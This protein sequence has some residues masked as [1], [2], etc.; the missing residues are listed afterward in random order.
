VV[1][2]VDSRRD[3]EAMRLSR[4]I[5][6]LERVAGELQRIERLRTLDACLEAPGPEPGT[7]ETFVA[8]A[9]RVTVHTQAP[10]PALPTEIIEAD[11]LDEL[12]VFASFLDAPPPE[13][14]PTRSP[15]RAAALRA[16]PHAAARRTRSPP[17]P[18][19]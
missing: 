10:P 4:E 3:L 5:A 2:L 11:H 12:I 8:Q 7:K 13:L 16:E 19:S 14:R 15:A 17:P 6:S 9:G 1:E 18:P